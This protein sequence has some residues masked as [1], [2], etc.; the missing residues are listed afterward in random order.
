M[1]AD[2]PAKL[3]PIGEQIYQAF[4]YHPPTGDQPAQYAAL[5]SAA[6]AFAEMIDLYCPN[7]REKSVS[8]T[9]VEEAVMWANAAI[10]RGPER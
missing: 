4:T 3:K 10:A 9:K 5:R 2:H 7:G 8:I 1:N 6:K